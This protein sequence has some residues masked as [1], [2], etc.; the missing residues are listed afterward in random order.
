MEISE[1]VKEQIV[2]TISTQLS[3]CEESDKD[4]WDDFSIDLD[5][6]HWLNIGYTADVSVYYRWNET[7]TDRGIYGWEEIDSVSAY[8]NCLEIFDEEG[9]GIHL[10]S[11]EEK[12]IFNEI[13][14]RVEQCWM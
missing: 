14:R 5:A 12:Q 11:E 10:T 7:S 13:E 8:L 9:N 1:K 4:Y 2:E 6:D 3:K